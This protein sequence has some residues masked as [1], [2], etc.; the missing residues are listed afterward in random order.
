MDNQKN[1]INLFTVQDLYDQVDKGEMINLTKKYDPLHFWEDF[2]D[3]YFKS[4]K[5]QREVQHY[6]P[7]LLERLRILKVK[8]LLDTGCGWG[9]VIPFLIDGCDLDSVTGLDFSQKQLN[10]A[11]DY[12]KDYPKRDKIT[13]TKGSAKNMKLPTSAFDCVI[14]VELMTHMHLPSVRY[15]LKNME[16]VTKKYII[17]V[18]RFVY[19]MEHPKLHMWTHNYPKLCF[20]YGYKVLESSLVGPGVIG[21]VLEVK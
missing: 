9:R 13:F 8:T 21:M 17:L 3:K 10:S 19:D 18:E 12:L 1:Q 5:K 6:I 14:S 4:F 7:F 20:D 2:G 16:R 15:V 11:N